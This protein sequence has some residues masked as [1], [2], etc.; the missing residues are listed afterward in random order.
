[1]RNLGRGA[2]STGGSKSLIQETKDKSLGNNSRVELSYNSYDLLDSSKYHV[3]SMLTMIRKR[4]TKLTLE[5]RE[6]R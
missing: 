4:V 3:V 2:N 6:S 1:M 5:Q